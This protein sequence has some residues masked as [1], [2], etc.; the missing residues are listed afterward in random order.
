VLAPQPAQSKGLPATQPT[1]MIPPGV[2]Y[3]MDGNLK[4]LSGIELHA[5]ASW[6]VNTFS[7]DEHRFSAGVTEMVRRAQGFAA[8][9]LPNKRLVVEL[10][11]TYDADGNGS[12]QENEFCAL[13]RARDVHVDPRKVKQLYNALAVGPCGVDMNGITG[14]LNRTFKEVKFPN[15]QIQ[16][17]QDQ[18][19]AYGVSSILQ[20][21]ATSMTI[22]SPLR[23]AKANDLFA[24]YDADK[25]MFIEMKEFKQ[26]CKQYDPSIDEDAVAQTFE[27]VGATDDRMDLGCFFRWVDMMFGECSDQDFLDGMKEMGVAAMTVTTHNAIR[28]DVACPISHNCKK[29]ADLIFALYPSEGK[30]IQG[31]MSIPK[32]AMLCRR[33][34]PSMTDS[35]VN[36]TLEAVGVAYGK[37][38]TIAKFY[39]WSMMVFGEDEMELEDGLRELIISSGAL[40]NSHMHPMRKQWAG[41]L[42]DAFDE[43]GSNSMSID[44]FSLLYAHVDSMFTTEML[45]KQFETV[46]C[47]EGSDMDR[48]AFERWIYLQ[49]HEVDDDTFLWEMNQVSKVLIY[50]KSTT[51]GQHQAPVATAYNGGALPSLS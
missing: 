9:P 46:G 28:S 33:Y 7:S 3:G 16:V 14:W 32:L 18:A 39:E 15:G 26:L 8:L 37:P 1:Q 44:E 34:D 12:L 50:I 31:E 2:G 49:Y 27:M 45:H 10:M 17:P 20:V 24:A 13:C 29:W 11:K 42:F 47:Q 5:I 30:N 48:D 40:L 23:M 35:A 6:L 21:A 41:R 4:K 22:L 19:F 25:S 36:T 51:L 38:L 43:D